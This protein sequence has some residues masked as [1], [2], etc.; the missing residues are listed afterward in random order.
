M[1]YSI[2]EYVSGNSVELLAMALGMVSIV[3]QI[4]QNLWLWPVNIIMVSLYIFVF[5]EARLYADMSLQ[6]YYLIM[7][8][9]GWAYWIVGKKGRGRSHG[10]TEHRQRVPVTNTRRKQWF[11]VAASAVL[12]Y[13]VIWYILDHYTN[14]DVPR[15][16]AFT[17]A[18]SFVAT[19]ML[20]RKLIE[21]WLIWIIVN[22]VSV[23]LYIYKGL[24]PTTVLFVV[25][26]VLAV[27]GYYE[28][29]KELKVNT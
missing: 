28:W 2:V 17:T 22:V 5:L 18:L 15:L 16:D 10:Q 11:I 1:I 14:S 3:L 19:W 21:H 8:I 13:L 29:K 23:G 6:V 12:F 4:K 9:Y 25:L 7:S 20:A 27:K 24:Y 26:A